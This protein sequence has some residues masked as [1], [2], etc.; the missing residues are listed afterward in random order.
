M[1]L[2]HAVEGARDRLPALRR[3]PTRLELGRRRV[4]HLGPRGELGPLALEESLEEIHLELGEPLPRPQLDGLALVVEDG[5]AVACLKFGRKLLLALL[6]R[7]LQRD[8]LAVDRDHHGDHR[9]LEHA[10]RRL[11]LAVV[12]GM[13]E[14]VEAAR[15]LRRLHRHVTVALPQ[16]VAFGG[17]EHARR[18]EVVE[19]RPPQPPPRRRK[20]RV[21]AVD[22]ADDPLRLPLE[23]FRLVE[24][25]DELGEDHPVGAR[26]QLCD[27]SGR[28]LPRHAEDAVAVVAVGVVGDDAEQPAVQRDADLVEGEGIGEEDHRTARPQPDAQAD[29]KE[30]RSVQPERKRL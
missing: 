17:G 19:H 14:E 18:V 13:R 16:R 1:A 22:R 10:V 8:G 3:P 21:R 6:Q 26:L 4:E 5:L 9:R 30:E 12:E 2:E 23:D 25:F 15:R 11:H 20:P 29:A 28:P 7:Q 27:C 24:I